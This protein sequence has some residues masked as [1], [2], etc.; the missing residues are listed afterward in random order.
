MPR[1][2]LFSD[3]IDIAV[4]YVAK[5]QL[6]GRPTTMRQLAK[7]IGL[8]SSTI[9]GVLEQH[10][11]QYVLIPY[12]D[13]HWSQSNIEIVLSTLPENIAVRNGF[14]VEEIEKSFERLFEEEPEPVEQE[15]DGIE[16]DIE[17][18]PVL[19][20]DPYAPYRITSAQYQALRNELIDFPTLVEE[21]KKR[22]YPYRAIFRAVGGDRMRY[23]LPSAVWRP[24]FYKKKRYYLKEVLNHL[25][26]VYLTYK[27][28]NTADLKR[29]RRKRAV[30]GPSPA[31]TMPRS[32]LW[33]YS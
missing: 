33:S 18:D 9:K 11:V 29:Y 3:V 4:S 6:Q 16:A 23:K 28:D 25:N 15:E 12:D 22:G 1:P 7:R 21:G 27:N 26:E 2:I 20:L 30:E 5:R 17:T 31:M 19:N 14:S 32:K 8:G 13:K 24:Y 10:G